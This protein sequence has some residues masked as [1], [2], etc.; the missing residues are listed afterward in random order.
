MYTNLTLKLF[1][2]RI[3]I[4]DKININKWIKKRLKQLWSSMSNKI[5]KNQRTLLFLDLNQLIIFRLIINK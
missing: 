3:N 1:V 5:E 2:L 4:A